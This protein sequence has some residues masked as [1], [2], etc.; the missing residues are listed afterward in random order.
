MP[1]GDLPHDVLSQL[2]DLIAVR[3]FEFVGKGLRQPP[4]D[5]QREI[6]SGTIL[7]FN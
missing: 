3:Q 5:A 2:H 1:F 7:R 4:V 6:H